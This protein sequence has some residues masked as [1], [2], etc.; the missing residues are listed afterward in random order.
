MSIFVI[1]L[2]LFSRKVRWPGVIPAGTT[3]SELLT[4]MDL[5]PTFAA[6]ADVPLPQDR[7]IDGKD[8]SLLMKGVS[9]DKSH[10]E[11]FFYYMQDNLEAVRS[12]DWKLYV[13]RKGQ[14]VRELYNLKTDIGETT[15]SI[16]QH[17]EIVKELEGKATEIRRDIGDAF[18]GSDGV[19]CRPAGRVDDPKPLT[20]FDPSHPYI[21]AMYDIPDFG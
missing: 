6:L 16:D 18:T 8:I 5:Y 21:V 9:G 1:S 14:E 3:C 15:N 13:S 4:A 7:I 17:P 19:N 11:A 12:G 20:G 2:L 10:H